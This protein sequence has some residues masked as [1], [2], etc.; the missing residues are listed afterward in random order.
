MSISFIVCRV[1]DRMFV[2]KCIDLFMT[3]PENYV[4]RNVV[5]PVG[6]PSDSYVH[7]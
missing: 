6:P 1:C 3:I 7:C 2:L 5:F 4:W